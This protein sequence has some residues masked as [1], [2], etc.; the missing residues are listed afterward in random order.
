MNNNKSLQIVINMHDGDLE[1]MSEPHIFSHP[2]L[3]YVSS[4][5]KQNLGQ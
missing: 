3:I 2:F 1:L 4:K 5:L